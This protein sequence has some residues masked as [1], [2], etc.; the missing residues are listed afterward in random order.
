[1]LDLIKANITVQTQNF[2]QM[3]MYVYL[4]VLNI[5]FK[6]STAVDVVAKQKG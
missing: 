1:M 2:S 4:G 6:Y 3:I 5:I